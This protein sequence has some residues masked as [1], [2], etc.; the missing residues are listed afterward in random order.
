MIK[1]V[2]I[3]G[4]EC[5]LPSKDFN[6]HQFIAR[7]FNQ[8]Y[9]HKTLYENMEIYVIQKIT[10]SMKFSSNYKQKQNRDGEQQR[11]K[12]RTLCSLVCLLI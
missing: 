8:F 7:S 4:G 5:L 2:S 10:M 12:K 11:P 1:E 9:I 3:Y 6:F